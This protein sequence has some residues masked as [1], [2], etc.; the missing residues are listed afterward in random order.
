MNN[1]N[2]NDFIR[3]SP[4]PKTEIEELGP[5]ASLTGTWVGNNGWNL[6]AVPGPQPPSD[7][8]KLLIAPY[9]EILTF[10]PVGA[11]VPNRG[12]NSEQF[13]PALF[14]ELRIADKETGRPLHAENGMWLLLDNVTPSEIV[15]YTIARQASVPHGDS[16]MA[17]G[18]YSK[19]M[20]AP[21]I[22]NKTA[23]PSTEQTGPPPIL[24]Y[25]DT[26]DPKVEDFSASN[27]NGTLQSFIA[28][29]PSNLSIVKTTTLEV[30]TANSGG[31][32][33]I[34]F[35]K[36]HADASSFEATYW[37]EEVQNSETGQIYLQLQY[38]QQTIL[39]FITKFG[40]TDPNTRIHWPHVNVNTLLKQ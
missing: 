14:Y 32:T 3:L 20:G 16:V 25:T 36:K 17:L 31:I 12:G 30:S 19:S 24:G 11:L 15:E 22:K 23:I 37:I 2:V 18:N 29:M 35:I 7:S 40:Q 33:N 26:Y 10:T 6:V 21:I 5:L 8:F 38:S 9:T 4:N 34:P 28:E 27:Y 13:V 1:A 39:E